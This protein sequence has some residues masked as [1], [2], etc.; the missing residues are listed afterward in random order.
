MFFVY[1]RKSIY[2]DADIEDRKK[3]VCTDILKEGINYLEGLEGDGFL[4]ECI[5]FFIDRQY[6][7]SEKLLNG[8]DQK[9]DEYLEFYKTTKIT[10]ENHQIVAQALKNASD[11][12]DLRE[13]VQ[14]KVLNEK[15]ITQQGGGTSKLFED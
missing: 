10:E 5:D 3:I 7:K 13:K 14:K 12:I 4:K 9:I 15:A 1:S 8:M 6:S 11:L 2:F